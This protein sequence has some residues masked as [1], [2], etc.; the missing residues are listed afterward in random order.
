[1]ATPEFSATPQSSFSDYFFSFFAKNHILAFYDSRRR[2]A[3]WF[4]S[5]AIEGRRGPSI[6]VEDY[7]FISPPCFVDGFRGGQC[8][9]MAAIGNQAWEHWEHC[10]SWGQWDPMAAKGK[11]KVR[12]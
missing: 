12:K 11:W 1:M 9:G 2:G 7:Y 4:L 10:E 3:R 5:R 8:N 6:T